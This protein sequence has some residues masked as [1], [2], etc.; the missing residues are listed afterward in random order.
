MQYIEHNLESVDSTN[1]WAR[2]HLDSFPGDAFVCITAEEQTAG[3]GRFQRTWVSP[4]GVNLYMTFA[5]KMDKN[6]LHL[7]SIGQVIA[8]TIAG[9]L[10]HEGLQPKIKWPNDVLL[11]GR[12]VAG[13]LVETVLHRDYTDVIAGIGLNVNMPPKDLANIDQPATSLLVETGEL[14]N[15]FFVRKQLQDRFVVD[16]LLFK[17]EGFTPFHHPFENLLAY[18]GQTIRC[19]DGQKEWTGICHSI[20]NDG[21]LNLSMPNGEIHVVSAGDIK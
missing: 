4:A 11:N 3:R 14:W 5:F 6:A 8:L 12:K 19:F 18:K 9:M 2:Q 16:F 20:T 15:R 13:V 1:N 17:K 21:R 7:N 10:I